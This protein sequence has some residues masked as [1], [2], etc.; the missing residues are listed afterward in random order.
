MPNMTPL[1]LYAGLAGD[2]NPRGMR[3]AVLLGEILGILTHHAA[4]VVGASGA[5]VP[6]GWAAQLNNNIKAYVEK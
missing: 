2:R 5:P 3:G 1:T 6:G 4:R